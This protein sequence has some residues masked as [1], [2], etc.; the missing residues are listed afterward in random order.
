MSNLV[1]AKCE[2]CET[3]YTYL[4]GNDATFFPVR[5]FLD[6]MIKSQKDLFNFDNFKQVVSEQ[7]SQDPTFMFQEESKRNEGIEKLYKAATIF[8]WENEKELLKS[9]ILLSF[10][11]FWAPAFLNDPDPEKRTIHNMMLL[12]MKFLDGTVYKRR[13]TKDI[14]FV[15]VTDNS[16]KF[17]CPKEM[18]QN[19]IYISDEFVA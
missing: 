1:K 19:A 7:L 3:E 9:K 4:F 14:L 16:K 6:G 15:Q 18:E 13:F 2:V 12:E 17:T 5:I 11:T 8:F 10:D